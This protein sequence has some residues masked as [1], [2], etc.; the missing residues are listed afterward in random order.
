MKTPADDEASFFSRRRQLNRLL[1]F[2]KE[3]FLI[4]GADFGVPFHP[5]HTIKLLVTA[6][7]PFYLGGV[8]ALEIH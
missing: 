1:V 3:K 2:L 4:F 5:S 8:F 7:E 6:S